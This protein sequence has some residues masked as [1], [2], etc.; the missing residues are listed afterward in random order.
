MVAVRRVCAEIRSGLQLRH[1]RHGRAQ[2][3]GG[4]DA[5]GSRM[6]DEDCGQAH[7]G[8]ADDEV[9][10]PRPTARVCLKSETSA[11]PENDIGPIG[12]L[13]FPHYLFDHR[14]NESVT[15]F[16]N[17]F[18]WRAIELLWDAA[19]MNRAGPQRVDLP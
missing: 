10:Q 5:L 17:L 9:V 16:E 12:T 6:R 13:A 1:L 19:S 8:F 14:G 2:R 4:A 11:L 7:G 18:R 3:I 15:S